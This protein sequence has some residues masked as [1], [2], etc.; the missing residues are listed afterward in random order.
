MPIL[1][2]SCGG[3][4]V[5]KRTPHDHN[6]APQQ[7]HRSRRVSCG[8]AN[9]CQAEKIGCLQVVVVKLARKSELEHLAGGLWVPCVKQV[10]GCIP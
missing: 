10:A 7:F 9:F 6:Q 3:V 2:K 5:F 4:E 1:Q 8:N